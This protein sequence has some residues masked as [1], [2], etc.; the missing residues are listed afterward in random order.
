M[1]KA[2]PDSKPDEGD[3]GS[4]GKCKGNEPEPELH[5]RE[6]VHPIVQ[7]ER[8]RDLLVVASRLLPAAERSSPVCRARRKHVS[9]SLRHKRNSRLTLN[10]R[11][12]DAAEQKQ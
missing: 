6:I 11:G 5:R 10:R 1:N 3:C 9:L 8:E 4:G 2:E 12:S 7:P